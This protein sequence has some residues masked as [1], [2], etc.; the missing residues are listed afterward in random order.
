MS[1][2]IF[3]FCLSSVLAL[4]A[5][6]FKA[7]VIDSLQEDIRDNTTELRELREEIGKDRMRVV[8][9]EARIIFLEKQLNDHHDKPA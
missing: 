3:L 2:E 8:N 1:L 4:F 6:V 5:F 9:H 7:F